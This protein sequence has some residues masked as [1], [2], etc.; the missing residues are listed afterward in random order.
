MATRV[1][2][3][4]AGGGAGNNLIRSLRAGD[5]SLFAVGCHDDR[6]ILK[7]SPANRNYLIP[8]STRPAF[9]AALRRVMET[10]R[11]DL[12]IPT[13]DADVRVLSR[14]RNRIPRRLFLPGRA[15]IELCQDKYELA[16]F[17]RSRGL[18]AP[19]TY[20]VTDLRRLAGV[21]RRLPRRDR[22]WCRIRT[23]SGSMG[24]IPVR[25]PEQARSW[26]RCWQGI[27]GVPA[28][29][30][31]LSEYLPGRDFGCQ[32]LWKAGTLV[33][34]KTYE[35]LSYLGTGGQPSPISS[36]AALAKTVLEPRVVETCAEAVRALDAKASGAFSIDLKENARGVPCITE[37]NAGRLSS[38]TNI[39]D[40]TGKH[41]MAV[42]YVRLGVG[43][44]VGI[45][46][47][48]DVAEDYY[49]L[50]DLDTLPGIFHAEEFF[51]GIDEAWR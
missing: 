4:G 28:T 38:A 3:M 19:V 11:I 29:A 33:L 34:I 7:C 46:D 9:A 12:L 14:L 30:F 31:T 50:R 20:P 21:F 26:I 16:T 27:R 42:T 39:F 44:P 17:L 22:V 5:P 6:F 23:G 37:I 15:T 36:V 13:S 10:E 43:E 25:S 18:P 2:V 1:L 8:A 40:L 32:S 51:D 48:Y 45:R 24:A 35:R 49:M 41:N 47:E